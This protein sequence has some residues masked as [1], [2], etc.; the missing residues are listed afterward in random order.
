[1]ARI[2]GRTV[3]KWSSWL[4]IQMLVSFLFSFAFCFSS[5]P[6]YLG[7][8]LRQQV[9]LLAFFLGGWFCS[10]HPVNVKNLCP[11]DIIPWIYLW[12]LLYNHKGFNKV[13]SEWP[14]GFHN[15]L[16]FKSEFCNK[17]LKIWAIVSYRSYF[18]WLYRAFPSFA[19]KNI[20]NLKSVLTI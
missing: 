1:M 5:I 16:Q 4:C 9:C 12:L 14:I 13:I 17:E 15:F 11:L 8:L 19:S 10:L 3:Q 20:N 6:A 2:H 7:G 18:C